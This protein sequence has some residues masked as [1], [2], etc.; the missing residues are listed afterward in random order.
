MEYY[1]IIRIIRMVFLFLCVKFVKVGYTRNVSFE[2]SVREQ[3]GDKLQ[4]HS[5]KNY[6]EIFRKNF[7]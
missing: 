5:S 2:K 1:T 7:K 6:C 4:L 3:R